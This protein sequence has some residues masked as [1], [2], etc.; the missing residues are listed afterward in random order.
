[1]VLQ[2]NEQFETSGDDVRGR[3]DRMGEVKSFFDLIPNRGMVFVT[4]V[5][6][7]PLSSVQ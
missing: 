1:M 6:L 5:R 3:F 7:L 4:Y 2:L